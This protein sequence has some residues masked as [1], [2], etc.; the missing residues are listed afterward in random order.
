MDGLDGSWRGAVC[1][2]RRARSVTMGLRKRCRFMIDNNI[3]IRLEANRA[4]TGLSMAEQIR[5]AVQLWL[6]TENVVERVPKRHGTDDG[7]SESRARKIA[8]P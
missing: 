3:A 5:R 2:P 4:R 6:E 8:T 7:R 1:Q